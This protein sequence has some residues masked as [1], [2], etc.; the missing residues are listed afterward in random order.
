MT[1]SMETRPDGRRAFLKRAAAT[2]SMPI[3]ATALPAVTSAAATS[4]SAA[5]PTGLPDFAPI[6]AA[7]NGPALNAQGYYVGQVKGDLYWV[8][9]SFYQA[10]FL[11]TREGVVLVD[12]PPT[13]GHNLLRAIA[14][15]TQA[16]GRPSK[17][18]HMVYSHSHADH[19]GAANIFGKDVVRIAHRECRKLLRRDA[20]PNRPLPDVVF[21]DHHELVVAGQ[22]LRLDFHGPNHSPD[23]IFI[24]APDHGALMVVDVL[25]PGWAPF[26]GLAVS[27]DIPDW[28]RAQDIVMGYRWSS[29]VGGHLGRLGVRA[30]GDVQRQYMADLDA[31]VRAASDSVDPTPFFQK[32]GPAGNSWAVFKTYLDAVAQAA[33]GPVAA[34][35]AGV[36]AAADVFTLD[37]AATLHES[38]RIDAGILGPFATRP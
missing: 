12:A 30:D 37:N 8:T 20:D 27:Q 13:I 23:N 17:V 11:S 16:N 18:T 36:L 3:L 32:Y 31:A 21:D 33:A 6:P 22:R 38:H 24:H 2:A 4:V 28:I 15:V 1:A 25:Y 5:E 34:K 9:D 35:Y 26:K 7:A 14:E 29:F 10:M 19:I